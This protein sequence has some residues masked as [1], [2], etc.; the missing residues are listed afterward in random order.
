[1][2]AILLSRTSALA[3]AQARIAE[4]A[5]VAAAARLGG[6]WRFVLEAQRSEGDDVK[7]ALSEVGGKALFTRALDQAVLAGKARFFG[8]L[9]QGYSRARRAPGIVLAAILPR[10]NPL[11]VLLRRGKAIWS[12][13]LPWAWR[14]CPQ[15]LWSRLL[16]PAVRLLFWRQGTGLSLCAAMF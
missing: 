4:A 3:R 2:E 1:M 9:R 6:D 11:D 10:G 5:L 12:R 7:Q 15:T 8:A 13:L 16:H 14:V